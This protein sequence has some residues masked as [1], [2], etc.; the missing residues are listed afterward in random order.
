MNVSLTPD[1]CLQRQRDQVNVLSTPIL[2]HVG[3]AHG[4]LLGKAAIDGRPRRLSATRVMA[5]KPISE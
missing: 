3:A 4:A 2:A 1:G 5:A